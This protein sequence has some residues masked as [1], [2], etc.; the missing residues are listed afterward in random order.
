MK[1]GLPELETFFLIQ[2]DHHL[3]ISPEELARSSVRFAK[4]GRNLESQPQLLRKLLHKG[5]LLRREV[6]NIG[7]FPNQFDPAAC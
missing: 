4:R 7:T 6:S 3:A 2:G 1:N 5:E